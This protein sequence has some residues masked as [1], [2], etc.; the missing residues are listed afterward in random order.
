MYAIGPEGFDNPIWQFPEPGLN[1]VGVIFGG[2]TYSETS[3]TVYFGADDGMLYALDA[4]TGESKL[5]TGG[6]FFP[7]ESPIWGGTLVQG[8][9]VYFGTMDG[10]LYGVSE[11]GGKT[12]EF[13]AGGAIAATPIVEGGFAYVGSFDK[14]FYAVPVNGGLNARETWKYSTNS[15]IWADALFGEARGQDM[16][17]IASLDGS[18]HAVDAASGSLLW[19]EPFV[20]SEGIRGTPAL[21][22]KSGSGGQF[23]GLS[24]KVLVVGSRDGRV[25][26]LDP[27][28]GAPVMG[29]AVQ[30]A[31]AGGRRGA[32]TGGGRAS[33]EHGVHSDDEIRYIRNRREHGPR[34]G[35]VLTRAVER[36]K[37]RHGH[38]HRHMGCTASRAH[39]ERA[40]I[41]VRDPGEQLWAEHH[42]VHHRG[43]DC[44]VPADA[45]ADQRESGDVAVAAEDPGDPA[46]VREGLA[47]GHPGDDAAVQGRGGEPGRVPGADGR[48]A[49]DLDRAVPVDHPGAAAE[50]GAAGRPFAEAVFM[51]AGGSHSGAAE[52]GFPVVRSVG[53]G[54]DE[55]DASVAG[56][57]FDVGAAEDDGEPVHGPEADADEPDDAVDDAGDVRV[58]HH[59]VPQ[60]PGVVLGGVQRDRDSIAVSGHGVG[61]P[62]AV[63]GRRWTDGRGPWKQG[64]R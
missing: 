18:V 57:G 36:R 27:Q 60:R 4:N 16:V 30:H 61:E 56:R 23:S 26:G 9:V 44:D 62:V 5:G 25:Y 2:V 32:D 1:T 24:D 41:P 17:F 54:P 3:N 11:N 29:L 28:T 37:T 10:R 49:A 47:E 12:L 59:P 52:Q 31:G 43:E 7:A 42:R 21:V 20:A 50:P 35:G 14:S 53:A 64:R 63:R 48:T 33:G 55:G 19:A 51:A 15:W 13:R 40:D 39:A 38:N 46:E 8:G 45:E 58:H 34:V 22:S 6:V